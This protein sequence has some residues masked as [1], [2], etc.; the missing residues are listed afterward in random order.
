MAVTPNMNLNLPTP[1]VT[2]GPTWAD[3][4]N[5]AFD[6]V[7]THN[8]TDGAGVPV[9]TAG[10]DIDDPLSFNSNAATELDYVAVDQQVATLGPSVVDAIYDVSGDLYF[11]NGS[12]TP[13]QITVGNSVNISATALV[14]PGVIWSYGGTSAPA[15][16]LL[17]N[18]ATIS[19]FTYSDLF[20]AIGETFGAGD[21]STTFGLPDSNGR[22]LIGAGTYLDP[23]LGSITRTL[24]AS[25]G[26][27]SHIQTAPELFAHSHGL[28]SH[29]HTAFQDISNG[30]VALP[31]ATTS[32]ARARSAG[33][34]QDY[35]MV[36]DVAYTNPTVG[37]TSAASGSTNNAGASSAANVMQ[38]YLVT[39]SII[40]Y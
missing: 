29:T 36:S 7:D 24:G 34:A 4:V 8:H 31:T 23:V 33:D 2:P 5:A 38:P 32:A 1:S 20:L 11:N 12:G 39:N 21:G 19:R 37:R 13:V 30:G 17:C 15:G 26:E 18:G 16:F 14:P 28:G 35:L 10:L 22:T 25:A 27:A 9:P 3:S 40:K 6:V